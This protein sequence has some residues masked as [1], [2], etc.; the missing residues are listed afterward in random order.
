MKATSLSS[1]A[2]RIWES[3]TE[4]NQQNI[5]D[6]LQGVGG[7]LVD[8]GC[9]D[10]AITVGISAA[11]GFDRTIGLEIDD[12]VA[13]VAAGR[14]VEVVSADL[15][16]RVPLPDGSAQ[17]IVANQIIEHLR[18][19]DS[20]LEEIKRVLKPGGV[21]ALS[22]ENISS[23]HNLLAASIGWQ[24]FSLTNISGLSSGVGNPVALHRGE[25]GT[26]AF[27]Q[28]LRIFAPRGLKE[29]AS[30]HELEPMAFRGAGYFPFYGR[31]AD[32]L[33]DADPRHSIFMTLLA[34]K[35]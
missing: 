13:S 30:L 21:V 23:W 9:G 8:F 20:F 35:R 18:D 17:A 22:T 34:R 31:A 14:G 32:A 19:T 16:G 15:N 5:R 6:L 29:L 25:S 2:E 26:P 12:E 7:T 11:D 10:G 3:A 4:R 27:M 33:S 24:P 1:I 28:H